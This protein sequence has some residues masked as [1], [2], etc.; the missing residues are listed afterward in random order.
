MKCDYIR[1]SPAETSTINTPNS[2]IYINIPKEDGV[3]SLLNSYHDL[4]L[5]VIKKADISRNAN[6]DG[7]RLVN[8][9][10]IAFFGN[11]MLTFSS[12]KHLE[13]VSNAYIVLL[14]HILITSA[15]DF[16]DLSIGFDRD[17][18]RRR[19]ELNNNKNIKVNILVRN[20]LMDVFGFAEH[21]EKATYGLGH[22]LTPTRNKDDAALQKAVVIADATI[23]I[24]H[25]PWYVPHYTASIQQQGILSK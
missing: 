4:N 19:N 23:K 3:I 1:H 2:Q 5:E 25:V 13:D 22:K 15:K 18:N 10:P 20:L 11:Y 7:I 17:C 6:G 24:A 9:D 12:G 16:D 8:F 21:Q 14:M